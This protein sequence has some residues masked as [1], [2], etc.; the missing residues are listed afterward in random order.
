MLAQGL[1]HPQMDGPT[2]FLAAI[3]EMTAV[4]QS[5]LGRE[6]LGPGDVDLYVLHQ[7]N[8]RIV[9]RVAQQLGVPLDRFHNTIRET[10]NT[11][12]ASVPIGVWSARVAG[13]IAPGAAVMLA[14]FG[15]GF[16]WSAALVRF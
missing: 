10:G 5:V 13:R 2:V 6:G 11:T 8:L 4:I 1:H 14:T 7:A 15:S 9:E 16:T 3:T 12:A